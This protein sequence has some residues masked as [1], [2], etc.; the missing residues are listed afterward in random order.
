M[1]STALTLIPEGDD[2]T[3]EIPRPAATGFDAQT[4]T[5]TVPRAMQEKS[6]EKAARPPSDQPIEA[7]EAS[8]AE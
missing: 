5:T 7:T 1:C 2:D 8:A 6:Q 4:R 3:I